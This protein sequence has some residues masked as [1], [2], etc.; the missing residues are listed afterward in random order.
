MGHQ[1]ELSLSGIME[2]RPDHR[3]TTLKSHLEISR[4]YV[5]TTYQSCSNNQVIFIMHIHLMSTFI[6]NPFYIPGQTIPTHH[7]PSMNREFYLISLPCHFHNQPF[8]VYYMPRIYPSSSFTTH[9]PSHSCIF[10]HLM[11]LYN[12]IKYMPS[13][14]E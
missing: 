5:P 8:H 13:I 3:S 6:T 4:N 2:L 12:P 10:I 1:H 7:P 11:S 14:Q 9:T